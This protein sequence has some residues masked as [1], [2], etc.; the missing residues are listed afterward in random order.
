MECMAPHGLSRIGDGERYAVHS[1]VIPQGSCRVGLHG[2]GQPGEGAEKSS[3]PG[4]PRYGRGDKNRYSGSS[5]SYFEVRQITFERKF[6]SVR[7]SYDAE[8]KQLS[9]NHF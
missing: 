5:N 8:I 2:H 3:E 1:R 4:C 7:I 9:G 6:S